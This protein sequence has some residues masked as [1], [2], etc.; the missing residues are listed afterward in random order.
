LNE[1]G[2]PQKTPASDLDS[3]SSLLKKACQ[4]L[5][6]DKNILRKYREKV[7]PELK[8]QGLVVE[9]DHSHLDIGHTMELLKS[10]IDSPKRK[11]VLDN[12]E[13]ALSTTLQLLSPVAS[14]EPHVALVCTGLSIIM[15]VYLFI[16]LSCAII[17]T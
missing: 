14:I 6:K 5:S 17:L 8:K 16:K 10:Q 2:P 15:L 11:E 7:I 4:D 1:F 12:V 3:A 9:D 13:K